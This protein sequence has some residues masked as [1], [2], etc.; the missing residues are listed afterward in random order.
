MSEPVL[1]TQVEAPEAQGQQ[2]E[3]PFDAQR[4]MDKIRK[5][6]SE[7]EGL[8]RRIK[9][10]EPQAQQFK[11]LE[12]ASKSELQRLTEAHATAQKD[13]DTARAEAI[14]YKAAATYGIGADHFDLLGSGTEDEISAR[15]EKV[16]ALIAAQAAQAT[17][18]TKPVTRPVEQLRPGATPGEALDEDELTYQALFGAPK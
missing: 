7:A 1:E 5:A 13:A 14:R 4:A 3:E 9:E 12:D 18:T 17:T 10:L 6:N 15:A 16:A 8:R 11:A 2:T